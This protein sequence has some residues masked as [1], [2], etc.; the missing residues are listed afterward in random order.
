MVTAVMM[1]VNLVVV[2]LM[3][4]ELLL[5]LIHLLITVNQLLKYK[6]Y[7]TVEEVETGKKY[8]N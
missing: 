6:G 7:C 4:Q 5:D 2:I 8:L 3:A 1:E